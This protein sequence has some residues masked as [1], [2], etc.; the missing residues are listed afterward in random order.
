MNEKLIKETE[1]KGF[2]MWRYYFEIINGYQH[3]CTF[4]Q[5]TAVA[6]VI[7]KEKSNQSEIF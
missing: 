3:S 1:L 7:K 5:R 6:N 2:H 4:F